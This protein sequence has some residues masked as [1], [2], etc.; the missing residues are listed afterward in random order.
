ML[1]LEATGP[2]RLLVQA[3]GSVAGPTDC[4]SW[5]GLGAARSLRRRD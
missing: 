4:G 1:S 2:T 3:D 5:H